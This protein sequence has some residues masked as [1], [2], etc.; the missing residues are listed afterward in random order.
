[1]PSPRPNYLQPSFCFSRSQAQIHFRAVPKIKPRCA[2]FCVQHTAV[3]GWAMGHLH[4]PRT[5][6]PPRSSPLRK[7]CSTADRSQTRGM[8]GWEICK[9]LHNFTDINIPTRIKPNIFSCVAI[10][11]AP[12]DTKYPRG[13]SRPPC[14]HT[15]SSAGEKT[16]I[17][18]TG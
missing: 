3:E 6:R 14:A 9:P 16:Q 13:T 4:Y 17:F 8:P 10:S 7:Y 18:G 15:P 1:M 2:E 12:R 5:P 11:P